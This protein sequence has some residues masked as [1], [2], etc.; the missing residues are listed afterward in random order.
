MRKLNFDALKERAEATASEELLGAISGG[1][2][3]SC[4]IVTDGDTT[5]IY[6]PTSGTI[7]LH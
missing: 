3:A 6:G 4:H 7:I 5:T 1:M 2:Q